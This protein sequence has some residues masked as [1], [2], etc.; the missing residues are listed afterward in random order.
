MYLQSYPVEDIE[1]F[2]SPEDQKKIHSVTDAILIFWNQI[3]PLFVSPNLTNSLW[4]I[5]V[6][7]LT[8]TVTS[9]LEVW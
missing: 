3:W 9:P 6:C 5:A 4:L 7:F 1:Y 8:S 2:D